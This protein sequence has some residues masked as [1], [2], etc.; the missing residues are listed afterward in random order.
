M[1]DRLHHGSAY[2]SGP[3]GLR[4]GVALQDFAL[5]GTERIALRL[6]RHWAQR[7]AAVTLFAGAAQGPLEPL[8]DP[9]L[10][11]VEPAVAIPRGPGSMPRLAAAAARYFARFPVDLCF[12]PGNY[13]WPI[14]AALGRLPAEVRPRI[15]VQVSAPLSKPQRG[16]VRQI[17]YEWRMRHL[18]RRADAVITLCA[19][20]QAEAMRILRHATCV[21]IPLPAL[22]EERPAPA[23]VPEGAPPLLLAIGR[24]V[25]EK[26]FD[27]LLDAF[28]A[29]RAR[30][31][32]RLVILGEGPA[33][34][35]LEAQIARLGIGADVSLPGYTGDT[36]AWLD[37]AR[38]LVLPSRFEGY[39]AVVVEALAA[40]RPVVA[41]RATPAAEELLRDPLAGRAVPIEDCAAL[42]A[43]IEALLA[44]PPPPPAHLAALVD[45]FQID[46]AGTRYERLFHALLRARVAA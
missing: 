26:G 3:S 9:R 16:P 6:A 28:A 12:V 40:G 39:G 41:T 11:L 37:R 10:D 33:R 8:L 45:R 43:G 32:A 34:P 24:L 36:R 31:G 35:A 38:L 4:I 46:D 25:P 14:A 2:V 21:T 44:A 17:G 29:L 18:L 1:H 7:G 13:H 42:A 5:G 15:A 22:D 19:S 30:H 20:A 23:P 27:L